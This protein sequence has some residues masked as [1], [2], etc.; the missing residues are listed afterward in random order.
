MLR[1]VSASAARSVARTARHSAVRAL[2]TER[3]C[4]V[5]L[6]ILLLCS[7]V[8]KVLLLCSMVLRV[9]TQGTHTVLYG[10]QG[11][12]TVLYGTQ[13]TI[14]THECLCQHR[15]H[16]VEFAREDLRGSRSGV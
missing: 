5:V 3:W 2:R 8:L 13:G 10:T 14:S 7:M 1:E 11:T 6:R 12:H 4:S 16:L 9:L 15:D